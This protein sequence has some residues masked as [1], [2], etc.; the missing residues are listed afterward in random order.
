[1][2]RHKLLAQEAKLQLVVAGSSNC[3]RCIA[4]WVAYTYVSSV[5]ICNTAK[6]P[7]TSYFFALEKTSIFWTG[8]LV[9]CQHRLL[10]C[11]CWTGRCSGWSVCEQALQRVQNS[12]VHRRELQTF[13]LQE[14]YFVFFAQYPGVV[15]VCVQHWTALNFLTS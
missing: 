11:C 3:N 14:N 13:I 8:E 7:A 5:Y 9:Q 15:I 10:I 1:V 12:K 2:C 4:P 6:H